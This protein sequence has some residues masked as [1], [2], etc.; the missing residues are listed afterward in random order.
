MAGPHHRPL[1]PSAW[2]SSTGPAEASLVPL[3][4]VKNHHGI[5]LNAATPAEQLRVPGA[6]GGVA[7]PDMAG[8]GDLLVC[9]A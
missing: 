1:Q 7:L 2:A 4:P 6:I 5:P 8:L 9:N 3:T